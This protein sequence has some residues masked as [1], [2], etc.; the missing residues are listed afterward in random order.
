MVKIIQITAGSERHGFRDKIYGLGDDGKVYRWK[1]GKDK[2]D[3]TLED[4][5]LWT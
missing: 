2:E 3:W 5:N 1:W 4:K